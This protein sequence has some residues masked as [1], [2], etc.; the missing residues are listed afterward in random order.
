[1]K[2]YSYIIHSKNNLNPEH[3]NYLFSTPFRFPSEQHDY[4]IFKL[5]QIAFNQTPVSPI[6]IRVYGIS[7]HF[8]TNYNTSDLTIGIYEYNTSLSNYPEILIREDRGI[9]QLTFKFYSVETGELYNFDNDESGNICLILSLK[10]I[11][12]K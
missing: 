3:I 5:E 8:Q 11:K 10:Q 9:Q 6:E 1:M 12:I 4:Y 2:Q 7:S